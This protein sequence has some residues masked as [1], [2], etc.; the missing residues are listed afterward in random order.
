MVDNMH[1]GTR[2]CAGEHQHHSG[3][4]TPRATDH[5]TSVRIQVEIGLQAPDT[6]GHFSV[7]P[8]SE[9][10]VVEDQTAFGLQGRP[11]RNCD[12]TELFCHI[13][14]RGYSVPAHEPDILLVKKVLGAMREN[15]MQVQSGSSGHRRF[16]IGIDR[17]HHGVQSH[18]CVECEQEL[19]S[20]AYTDTNPL[21]CADTP[22]RQV[23]AEPLH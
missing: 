3:G 20:A 15:K 9:P 21:T 12:Q 6:F 18:Q 14:C 5:G 2:C 10:E 19:P 17:H 16:V 7:V 13:K 8:E 11:R 4:A 1:A 23:F 22:R